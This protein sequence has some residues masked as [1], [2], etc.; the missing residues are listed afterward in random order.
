MAAPAVRPS[1]EQAH[2]QEMHFFGFFSS[3]TEEKSAQ[4]LAHNVVSLGNENMFDFLDSDDMEKLTRVIGARCRDLNIRPDSVEG[5]MLAS[6]FLNLFQSGVTDEAELSAS[7]IS[8]EIVKL[9]G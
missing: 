9:H 6:Q 1:P 4:Y 7:P 5:Q 2:L 3:C 8:V